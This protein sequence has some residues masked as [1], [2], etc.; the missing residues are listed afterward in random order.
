MIG[1]VLVTLLAADAGTPLALKDAIALAHAK[2]PQV[3]IASADAARAGTLV[4][5]GYALFYPTVDS[6]AVYQLNDRR[7]YSP[8]TTVD[9]L[10]EP[11]TFP[12]QV[13]QPWWTLR[14]QVQVQ[15]NL[16]FHGPAFP[17]L[18]QA[19][20]GARAA[21]FGETA[22]KAD[23]AFAVARAYYA[24][25]TA[26]TVVAVAEDAVAAARELQRVADVKRQNGRATE[27]EVLRAKVRVAESNQALLSAKSAA[28][29][30]RETIADLIG[31]AGPFTLTRPARPAEPATS[32]PPVRPDLLA[33]RAVVTGTEAARVAAFRNWY[34]TLALQ[35]RYSG[36]ETSDGKLFGQPPESYA[37]I[38]V[39]QM[40]IFD[41]TLKYWQ[42]REAKEQ[43]RSAR[44]REDAAKLA[45]D[46]EERRARRRVTSTRESEL[47]A[48]ER[49]ALA[50]KARELVAG[51]YELGVATQ[52]ERLDADSA[53]AAA[54]REAAASELEADLAVLE[55]QRALGLAIAP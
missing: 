50:T 35:G 51:Q 29:E 55:L 32:T 13:F 3:A 49:L 19:K 21:S 14:W 38:G 18:R 20:A 11:V 36:Y 45:A 48:K 46:A 1:F 42:V 16:S 5:Q 33:A 41:G 15:Q 10:G 12:Q 28:E 2:N 52:L 40:S 53:F 43:V 17:L 44:A 54:R 39:A 9:I 22:V 23:V 47:L 37:L 8:E 25:L 31:T 27:A 34:P 7:L 6:Q 26:D 30:A 24:A 4:K